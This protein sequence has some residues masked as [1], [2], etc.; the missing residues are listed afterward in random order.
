[1]SQNPINADTIMRVLEVQTALLQQIQQTQQEARAKESTQAPPAQV[2]PEPQQDQEAA[3]RVEE[4]L[5]E[6]ARRQEEMAAVLDS[7]AR[8]VPAVVG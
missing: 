7:I 1:M 6:M 2:N 8:G 3:G 4:I 5:L